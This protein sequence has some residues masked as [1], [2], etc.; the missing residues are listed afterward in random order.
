MNVN[1]MYGAFV[2]LTHN[3]L[4]LAARCTDGADPCFDFGTTALLEILLGLRIQT[5]QLLLLDFDHLFELVAFS[6]IL[7]VLFLGHRIILKSIFSR[8][9][10]AL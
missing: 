8:A 9:L 4:M 1:D 3:A 10:N 6:Q 7:F 2:F 5:S